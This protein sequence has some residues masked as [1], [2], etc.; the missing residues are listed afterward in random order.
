MNMQKGNGGPVSQFQQMLVKAQGALPKSNFEL[1]NIVILKN[2]RKEVIDFQVYHG[3][4][5][6]CAYELH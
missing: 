1:D 5:G 4:S 2:L 3:L 6:S